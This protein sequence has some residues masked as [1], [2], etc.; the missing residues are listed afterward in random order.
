MTDTWLDAGVR[1]AWLVDP[2]KRRVYVYRPGA[3][4]AT[5]TDFSGKLSAGEVVPGFE[6][7]LSEFG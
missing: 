4:V 1:L 3:D 5:V 6:M 7:D 2:R